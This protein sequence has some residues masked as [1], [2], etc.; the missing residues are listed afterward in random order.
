MVQRS[1]NQPLPATDRTPAATP[2][3]PL[4]LI[5]GMLA[6]VGPMS[7]DMY[8]PALPTIAGD[9]AADAGDVQLSLSVFFIGFALVQ[10]FYGPLS[11][12]FG[13]R[14]VLIGGMGLYI[15]T[16]ALCAL[17]PSVD[18]LIGFRALQALGGGAGA[19]ISRAIVRDLY[20]GSQASRMMSY[21]TLV[22]AIAP[23]LAPLLGGQVLL[24]FGWRTIFWILCGFGV[25]CLI[26]VLTTLP[27]SNPVERRRH[28]RLGPVF[29]GYLYVLSDRGAVTFIASSSAIFLGMFAYISGTPFVYIELFHVSPQNYGFLFGVN[30]IALMA[31]AALNGR[32]VMRFGPRRLMTIGTLIAGTAA[33]VLLLNVIV[34]FG[35]LWGIVAPLFFYAG[36][37]NLIGANGM[38]LAAERFG[39][40]AGAVSALFGAGQ[41]GFGALGATVLAAL[42][43]GTALPMAAVIAAGGIGSFAI[44]ATLPSAPHPADN[45]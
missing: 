23:L 33:L 26:T 13:R 36:T 12:L 29:V 18:T 16:S 14:P 44:L 4:V 2:I 45:E 24:F 6:A 40:N 19:V 32:L 39:S 15:G 30:I 20:N 42:N 28:R 34:G 11:D 27:E 5:L 3:F 1:K 9:L 10:L 41:F 22:I 38:V 7:I 35:G 37:L 31:G 25:L 17:S 21:M 43:D 8:L